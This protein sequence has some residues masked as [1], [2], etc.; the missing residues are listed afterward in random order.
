MPHISEKWKSFTI[1]PGFSQSSNT[2]FASNHK[3]HSHIDRKRT[4]FAQN[5][6]LSFDITIHHF[7][8]FMS[9]S[10][11]SELEIVNPSLVGAHTNSSVAQKTQEKRKRDQSSS[12]DAETR[13]KQPQNADFYAEKGKLFCKIC[14]IRMDHSRQSVLSAHC[15]GDTH[16]KQKERAT[17]T[18]QIRG[19]LFTG[20]KWSSPRQFKINF[21]LGSRVRGFQII[22]E[23]RKF[24]INAKVPFK[25]NSFRRMNSSERRFVLLLEGLLQIR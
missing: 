7:D 25:A 9:D 15:I 23:C 5:F 22:F 8:F 6:Q 12:I 20:S 19:S 13:A 17:Q 3:R 10:T 18:G 4:K 24:A 1:I 14:C 11:D 21:R 16:K 2:L